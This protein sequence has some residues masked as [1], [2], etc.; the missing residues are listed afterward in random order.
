MIGPEH[1]RGQVAAQ[2]HQKGDGQNYYNLQQV[3]NESARPDPQKFMKMAHGTLYSWR[4]DRIDK[5][6]HS[7]PL[8]YLTYL[9]HEN[10]NCS[11]FPD[12]G[13]LVPILP[14]LLILHCLHSLFVSP[15]FQIVSFFHSRNSLGDSISLSIKNSTIILSSGTYKSASL[16][17]ILLLSQTNNFHCLTTFSFT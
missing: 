14:R 8:F 1:R 7:L 6:L 9:H 15:S 5:Y 13:L 12:S 3:Q 4:Q 17:L 16:R 11:N 10:L 2:T